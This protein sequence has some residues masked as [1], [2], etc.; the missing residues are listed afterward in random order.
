[1]VVAGGALWKVNH[2]NERRRVEEFYANLEA[3]K[4]STIKDDS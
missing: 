1:M 4:I 2:W 3:G